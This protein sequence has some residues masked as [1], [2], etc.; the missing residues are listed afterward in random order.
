MTDNLDEQITAAEAELG[1]VQEQTSNFKILHSLVKNLC[2]ASTTPKPST[3]STTKGQEPEEPADLELNLQIVKSKA[4]LD[5]VRLGGEHCR[6]RREKQRQKLQ[7]NLKKR[8]HALERSTKRHVKAPDRLTQQIVASTF[9]EPI[10]NRFCLDLKIKNVHAISNMWWMNRQLD[11]QLEALDDL[12]ELLD[13]ER[14]KLQEE[15][16]KNRA[17][18]LTLTEIVPPVDNLEFQLDQEHQV[19]LDQQHVEISMLEKQQ[20]LAPKLLHPPSTP[21]TITTK[22]KVTCNIQ[23]SPRF[24]SPS[25]TVLAATFWLGEHRSAFKNSNPF[26]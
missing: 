12:N 6:C 3:S 19:E 24:P 9:N 1:L 18:M 20:Q 5:R 7:D 17:Q 10:R 8:T 11:M 16:H 4:E 13:V 15:A 2:F 21:P 22:P 26:P 23:F 14:T 25:P